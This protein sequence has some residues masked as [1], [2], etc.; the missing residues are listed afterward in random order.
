[1]KRNKVHKNQQTDP[2]L[3][4]EFLSRAKIPW[5]KSKEDIWQDLS[6]HLQEGQPSK[7]II[8]G[9]LPGKQ[10]LAMAASIALLLAVA[11][12][13]RFSTR[14][15][16]TLPT[17]HASLELPDGS[18]A[19]LNAVSTLKFHP[20]W[21]WLSRDV[22][23]E[24]EA[25]FK[26]EK[27]SKFKVSSSHAVTEALGTSFNVYSRGSDYQVVCHSGKVKVSSRLSDDVALL[28]PEMKA[29]MDP[30]GAIQVVDLDQM[31]ESPG[32][33]NNLLMFSSVPLRLVF[34]EIER[35]YGIKIITP[36]EMDLR[37][38]GN[39][40]LES[41]VENVLTLL[42]MPF[43]LRYEQTSGKTYSILPDQED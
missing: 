40:A 33:Q 8:P 3:S 12:F 37:F 24:G 4:S 15:L 25:F 26:V 6:D 10:W 27:G 9:K 41:S 5:E 17:E 11:S 29:S 38:S 22:H 1:M 42:C 20:Y 23:L 39:F 2:D 34:D 14:T 31:E 7:V 30:S 13:L 28:A 19:E 21:W 32:W 35:Q 16:E 36:R 18:V 43:D